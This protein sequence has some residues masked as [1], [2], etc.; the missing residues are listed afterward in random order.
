MKRILS[1]L[2]CVIILFNFIFANCSYADEDAE[3][4][5]VKQS[6]GSTNMS[7][8]NGVIDGYINEGSTTDPKTG[9]TETFDLFSGSM[10]NVLDTV[11]GIVC[12]IICVIPLTVEVALTVVTADGTDL[13][14]SLTSGSNSYAFSIQKT[15]FNE[16]GMFNVDYFDF[17]ENSKSHNFFGLFETNTTEQ[18]DNTVVIPSAIITI[19]KSV[20]KWFVISRLVA[21]ATSVVVLIYIGI[22]MAISTIASDKAKYKKM[23]VG[24]FEA[25]IIL[26]LLQYIIQILLVLGKLLVDMAYL[27]RNALVSAG[28]KSFEQNLSSTIFARMLTSKGSQ[29]MV[30]TLMLCCLAFTH[31]RFFLLYIKRTITIGFLI[32]I[33]PLITITYPLDKLD[34]NQAQAFHAWMDE[35]LVNIFIQPIHAV[36]YLIFSFTAGE[37]ASYAP[38]FALIF[39]MVIPSAEKMVRSIFELK[40]ATVEHLQNL[41][42]PKK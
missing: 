36:I 4:T 7:F 30:L 3:G 31:V 35:L 6:F 28:G 21:M 18:G 41:A 19:K 42:K 8:S 13:L 5:D 16:I 1:T 32:L 14:D 17:N 22:R 11:L 33:S 12:M 40:G 27:L 2:I 29:L 15:V 10:G 25:M 38:L 39:L 26:F 9:S 23:L 24:W 20:A 34:D 37:I